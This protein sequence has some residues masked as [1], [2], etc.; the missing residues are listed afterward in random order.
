[1]RDVNKFVE[2]QFDRYLHQWPLGCGSSEGSMARP[3]VTAFTAGKYPC[4]T[5]VLAAQCEDVQDSH[6]MMLSYNGKVL[7]PVLLSTAKSDGKRGKQS[8]MVW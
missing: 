4:Q 8:R 3:E 1:M 6:D 7:V 5:T 2:A